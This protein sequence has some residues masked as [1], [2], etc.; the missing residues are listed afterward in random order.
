MIYTSALKAISAATK[1]TRE[2]GIIHLAGR[3]TLD[4][5]GSYVV[6]NTGQAA[7]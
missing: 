2:T 5:A 3:E 6:I 1:A 4:V 7:R